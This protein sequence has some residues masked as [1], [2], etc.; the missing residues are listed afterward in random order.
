MKNLVTSILLSCVLRR[1]IKK[2][3]V[4]IVELL[5]VSKH[6]VSC[7]R[8]RRNI[9]INI[10]YDLQDVTCCPYC[11]TVIDN[12]KLNDIIIK[13]KEAQEYERNIDYS[14]AR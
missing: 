10:F 3:D 11:R 6:V 9:S 5:R 4:S 12:E 2:V 13:E 7:E 14:S 1:Y 8:C